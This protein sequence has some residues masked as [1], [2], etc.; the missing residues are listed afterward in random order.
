[1]G[2][3]RK[4]KKERTR[5]QNMPLEREQRLVRLDI[6]S[7]RWDHAKAKNDKGTFYPRPCTR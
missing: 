6:Q 1:M 7:A 2:K 4:K 5:E 3:G